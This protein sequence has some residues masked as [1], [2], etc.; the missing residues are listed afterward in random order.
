MNQSK[1]SKYVV[2]LLVFLV[3]T[4]CREST[5]S[6]QE[7]TEGFKALVMGGKD[8]DLNQTWS[9]ATNTSVNVTGNLQADE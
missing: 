4:S 8:I 1:F 2:A 5:N 9:T 3:A 7:R 6:T